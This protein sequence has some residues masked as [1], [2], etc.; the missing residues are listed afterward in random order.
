MKVKLSK[1]E[2]SR[3]AT[4]L[5]RDDTGE[6]SQVKPFQKEIDIIVSNTPGV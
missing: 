3:F 5:F 2:S 4:V 1:C 6:Q